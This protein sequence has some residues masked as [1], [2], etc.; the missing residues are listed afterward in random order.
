MVVINSNLVAG[1]TTHQ[2]S[3]V[4]EQNS[5]TFKD[6]LTGLQCSRKED[7]RT[8]A[9]AGRTEAVSATTAQEQPALLQAELVLHT[10]E[11]YREEL[12]NPTKTAVDLDRTLRKL[13]D[14]L[15]SLSR[16]SLSLTPSLK[17]LT[18]EMAVTAARER[19][20]LDRGDYGSL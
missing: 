16:Q 3:K 9:P 19:I 11:E 8:A 17:V 7:I 12:L 13:D 6:V 18:Q 2:R 20:K 15:L 14:Q 5:R 1:E 4:K 10:M